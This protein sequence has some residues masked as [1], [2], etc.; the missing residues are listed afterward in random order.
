M[1]LIQRVIR[2]ARL[3]RALYNEV[4]ADEKLTNEAILVVVLVAAAA[5]IG[6]FLLNLIW[7]GGYGFGIAVGVLFWTVI[8]QVLGYGIFAFLCY[9]VGTKLAFI[10]G[11]ATFGELLRTLGYAQGPKVLNLLY[12]I[13]VLGGIIYWVTWLWTLVTSVVAI[14]EA[15]DV[16]LTKS[17]I[18]AAIAWVVFI[19]FAVIMGVIAGAIGL[20]GF[21]AFGF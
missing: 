16:D 1:L 2:A 21:S 11:K 9:F 8:V 19:V 10:G 5:G 17:I 3:D 4:E 6:S 15:L 20:W 13:P 7:W 18:T 14:Q 12:F